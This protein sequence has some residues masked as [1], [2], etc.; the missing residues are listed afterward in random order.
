VKLKIT[1]LTQYTYKDP[2]V[3]SVN[4]LRL[5]PINDGRQS[6]CEHTI[7]I[8]PTV[9][10]F[11]Y[12]D[13]FGN[14]VHYFTINSPHQ[15][16]TI[17]MDSIVETTMMEQ[18]ERSLLTYEEE[19]A[20]LINKKFQNKYAYYLMETPY[21]VITPELKK[22]VYTFIDENQSKSIYQLLEQI[23]NAIYSNFT[24]DQKVTNVKTTLEETLRLKRGVCQDYAHIMI[25]ICRIFN[26]PSRYVSGYHFIGDIESNQS[27]FQHASHAWVEAY[28]PSFGWVGLDPTNNGKIDFRYVK[29]SYGRDYSDIVPV[30][31]VY[32][33]SSNQNLK[34]LVDIQY[35]Q[36]EGLNLKMC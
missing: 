16:L 26:I 6:C 35:I 20:I 29:L 13:Y 3:D 33:G 23:S 14:L 7:M 8:D 4:E 17:K 25:A 18:R 19:R 22:F 34:V 2:V 10:L 9:S 24:Y 12:T 27:N 36:E 11:P 30:K 15:H 1:H 21:S 5:S 28:V 32:K 31:G